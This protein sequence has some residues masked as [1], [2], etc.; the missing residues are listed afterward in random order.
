MKLFSRRHKRYY[1]A[2]S[3][4]NQRAQPELKKTEELHQNYRMF[5][6]QMY[7]ALPATT[8]MKR[9]NAQQDAHLLREHFVMQLVSIFDR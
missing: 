1:K 3:L 9:L 4:N 2:E 6:N 5:Q 8:S 7:E